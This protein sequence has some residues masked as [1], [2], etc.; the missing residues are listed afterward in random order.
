MRTKNEINQIDSFSLR[1]RVRRENSSMCVGTDYPK[2]ARKYRYTSILVGTICAVVE[3]VAAAAV[4]PPVGLE[5]FPG[6]FPL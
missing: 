2:I 1:F 6:L 4:V 5:L 3:M